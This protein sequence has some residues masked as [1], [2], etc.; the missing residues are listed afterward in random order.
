MTLRAGVLGLGV[1]GRHHS[2]VLNEL[3]GVEFKGVY[4]PSDAVPSHIEGKPVV[5]DLDTF[6]DMGFDYCVVAAPTIYHLEIGTML[7]SRGIHAL[8]EKPVAS[9]SEAAF[10]LR[11]LFD[12]AGLVGGVGHIERYNPALQSARQRIQDGLLGEIYQVTTRRQGPFPGR[13]AD[14]G[15]IKD[16]ATHD[17]DLTAWV[18]QQE[19]VSINART[20]FRSG[21]EH[22]DM[23]LAVGTL[24]KGTIVSHTVNWLTPF[25]ERTTIITGE[26]GSLVADTL[27]ADLTYF[28]NG[29]RHH[30]WDDIS[31][32]RGVSEGDVTRFALDKKEPL[33]AEHEAFRDAVLSGDTSAIVTLAQGAA[34]VA[35]AEK[36]V[37]DGLEHRLSTI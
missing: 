17:I 30:Q 23:V 29:V 14:V 3:D 19:Y 32:F 18:T 35:T 7:A 25:K 31:Q 13:I 33:R 4:D 37:A 11:D 16:L 20:T 24:S 5:R 6:L 2:R 10:E 8:I 26:H 36:F 22:E 27:T 1:M 21:R 9:T 34:V 12:E 28:E 15:V